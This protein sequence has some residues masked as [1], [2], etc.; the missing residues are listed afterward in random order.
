MTPAVSLEHV[1]KH[2]HKK[3]LLFSRK[4]LFWAIKDLSL[5]IQQG[6]M[7]TF[8][9]A[10]GAGKSTLMRLIAGITSPTQGCVRVQG[11][12]MPILS[13]DSCLSPYM[14]A[15][16]NIEFLMSVYRLDPNKRKTILPEIIAF[17]GLGEFPGM[18]VKNFSAGMRTRLSFSIAA[19]L[20]SDVFI[21]DEVLLARD[22]SFREKSLDMLK[23]L[24]K[25]GK[26][27]FFTTHDLADAAISDRII[28]LERGAI[29][30]EGA[31]ARVLPLYVRG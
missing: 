28:W 6:E 19:H 26:T 20:P 22:E 8:L 18:P 17:S 2:Y 29:K 25:R 27:L 7:V 9:G 5:S 14:T 10:N 12:A 24:R 31:P 1:W 30:T 13:M 4:D 15:E 23:L 16:E 21:F 3:D 11:C